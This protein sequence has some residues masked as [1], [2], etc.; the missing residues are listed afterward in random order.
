[1]KQYLKL[2]RVKHWL[3]NGLVFLPLFFSMN[4]CNIQYLSLC[5]LAFVIFSLSSSVVYVLNDMADVEKDKLHPIKKNRPLASGAISMAQ[6]KIVIVILCILIAFMMGLL[7]WN[8]PNFFIILIPIVYIIL[9]LLYSKWLKHISIIDVVILVSGFVLRVMYGGVVV[10][11]V[12]SKYLY[13]MIIFGSFYLGFGKR[14]N[15]MIKNGKKSRKVLEA[16]NQAFLDKNMYVCLALA[17]VSYS[18]WCVDPMTIARTGH[19][20]LFWT[21]PIL[22]VILQLYSLNIEGSSHGDPIEVV[23]S[24]KRLLVV[25][26]LYIFGMTGLLYLI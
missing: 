3:K 11:V 20:Y 15:E 9:N 24:D 17:I 12:V 16:Y 19:D 5:F 25:I 10:D 21:I 18:L 2:I 4:L 14:R 8:D 1:M 22:M 23:L 7:Y 26:V 13:L 6:A